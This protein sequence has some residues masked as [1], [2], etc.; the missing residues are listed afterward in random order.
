MKKYSLITKTWIQPTYNNPYT[1]ARLYDL[2]SDELI[3]VFKI[4]YNSYDNAV[5]DVMDWLRTNKAE[6]VRG[7]QYPHE[8]MIITQHK[9]CL[10]KE[11]EQWGIQLFIN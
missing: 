1:S 3:A 6:D 10:K 4:S 9:K 5:H 7:I 8:I 2:Q 11:V